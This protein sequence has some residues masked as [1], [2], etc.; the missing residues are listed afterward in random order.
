MFCDYNYFMQLHWR[1]NIITSPKLVKLSECFHV[2]FNFM[3]CIR[4]KMV[5]V[6]SWSVFVIFLKSTMLQSWSERRLLYYVSMQESRDRFRG[7]V[8]VT[9]CGADVDVAYKKVG[10]GHPLRLWKCGVEV[11]APPVDVV[12]RLLRERHLWDDDMIKWRVVQRLD[13]ETEV[14]QYVVNVMVPH[15]A[16]DFCELRSTQ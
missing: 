16:R 8:S 11:A 12:E 14:F 5:T 9:S 7:W 3:A 15:P 6:E 10:D 4:Y 2:T 13:N 1:E